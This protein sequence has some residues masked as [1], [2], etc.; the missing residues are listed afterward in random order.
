MTN[1]DILQLQ[2]T[3]STPSLNNDREACKLLAAHFAQLEVL[4]GKPVITLEDSKVQIKVPYFIAEK[5]QSLDLSSLNKL[6]ELLFEL[7]GRPVVLTMI[8]LSYPYSESNI[9]AQFISIN[10]RKYTFK[11][12]MASLTQ[13]LQNSID[14]NVSSALPSDI[15][16]IKVQICGRLNSQRSVPRQ[17]TQTAEMGSFSKSVGRKG[18]S[19]YQESHVEYG[20]FTS[21][22]MKGAFTVKVWLSQNS[23][24]SNN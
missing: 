1:K 13:S 7:Y 12:I 24:L 3:L 22:N 9:L 4:L 23:R 2:S 11:S 19:A 14:A 10:A 21:K 17:T 16:G 20:S 6:S 8:R 15:V 18:Q 5:G